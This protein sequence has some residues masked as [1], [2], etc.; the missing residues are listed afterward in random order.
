MLEHPKLW[1]PAGM[2]TQPLYKVEIEL[3]DADGKV[4]D[5]KQKRIGLR[6][7]EA[8]QQTKILRRCNSS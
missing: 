6:T 4:L 5:T 2:G 3:L 7:M 1:W 8:R